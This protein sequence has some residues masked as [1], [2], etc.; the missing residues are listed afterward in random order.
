MLVESLL[1]GVKFPFNFHHWKDDLVASVDRR[2]AAIINGKRIKQVPLYISP[3]EFEQKRDFCAGPLV[4]VSRVRS[5]AVQAVHDARQE[6]FYLMKCPSEIMSSRDNLVGKH[7]AVNWEGGGTWFIGSVISVRNKSFV[8]K[9]LADDSES[10]I[11]LLHFGF[12]RQRN[13]QDWRFVTRN[14]NLFNIQDGHT[15]GM[16]WPFSQK[17]RND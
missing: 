1:N 10:I 4:D 17:N 14:S 2:Y 13:G 9:W 7:V 3:T 6:V 8:V 5:Q 12:T 15:R 16:T 11:R